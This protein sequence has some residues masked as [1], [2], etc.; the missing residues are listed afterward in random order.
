MDTKNYAGNSIANKPVDATLQQREPKNKPVTT[1]V[2]V[3]KKPSF[4]KKFFAEDAKTVGGHVV[5]SVLIPS[6]QRLLSDSVKGAIDWL[7]YGSKGSGRPNSGV[8]NVSY[9]SY[10]N[11]P[12]Y[13]QP[14]NYQQPQKPSVYSVNDITFTDQTSDDPMGDATTVLARM[15][16]IVQRYGVASVADFYDLVGQKSAYTDTKYGWRDLSQ[17]NIIRVRDGYSILFPKVSPIE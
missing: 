12:N 2:S 10:Y 3:N 13:G 8:G 11:R 14:T 15:T 16:E 4:I 9:S 17:A 5:E 6:L 7:I 1:S